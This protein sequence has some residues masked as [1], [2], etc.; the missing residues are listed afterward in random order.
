MLDVTSAARTLDDP[1]IEPDRFE[2]NDEVAIAP[3]LWGRRGRRLRATIDFWDDSVD[4]YRVKLRRGMRLVA[5]L[6]GPRATNANLFLWKP[7]TRRIQ[8]LAVKRRQLAAQSKSRTSI[9][10]IRL[11]VRKSGWYYLEVKASTP[12]AGPYTLSFRKRFPR[13]TGSVAL[14]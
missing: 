4:L 2:A 12:G 3:Q 11:R 7:G 9:E 13:A 1:I 6:R 14:P 5:R 10:R 8:G